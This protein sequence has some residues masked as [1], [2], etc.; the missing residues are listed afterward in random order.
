VTLVT[1]PY[2][3]QLAA[4]QSEDIGMVLADFDAIL[5]VVNGDIRNDNISGSAGIAASKISGYPSD[6]SKFLSGGGTWVVPGGGGYLTEQAYAANN[7][8]VPITATTAATANTLVTA[9]AFSA[10]GGIYWI[11]YFCGRVYQD[12]NMREVV[13]RLYLDGTGVIDCGAAGAGIGGG[14]TGPIYETVHVRV[15]QTPAAGSRTY[16]MRAYMLGGS[17]TNHADGTRQQY[18]RVTKER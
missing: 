1:L 8:D 15:P 16:S 17:G 2:R 9:P 18:I 3:T 11:E 4:G 13:F 6:A 12:S 10:D 5:S 7:V 14:V